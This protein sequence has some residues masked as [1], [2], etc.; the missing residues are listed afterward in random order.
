MKN[1]HVLIGE[2]K[3]LEN[4]ILKMETEYSDSDFMVEW[5]HVK[6][7]KTETHFVIMLAQKYRFNGTISPDPNNPEYL[8]LYPEGGSRQ[9]ARTLDIVYLKSFDSSF[10]D[11]I[12]AN[13]DA[14]I[15]LTKASDT[16]QLSIS[17]SINYLYTRVNADVYINN[18]NN[19]VQDTIRTIRNNYGGNLKLYFSKSWFVLSASDFLRSDEQDLD[20]R[21]TIQFGAGRNLIR[22][23][24]MF[25]ISSA[26]VALN[27]EKFNQ[28]NLSASNSLEVFYEVE[29]NLFGLEDIRLSTKVQFFTNTKDRER[30]RANIIFDAKFDLPLDFYIGGNITYNYDSKTDD[31]GS[32]SDYVIKS[33]VG[34]TF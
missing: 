21:T 27:S 11:R 15:S 9:F 7:L 1:G 33:S 20:L 25:L 34:W 22:N 29:Y 17:G 24:K 4:G 2:I 13:V 23:Y 3:V 26:G 28:E 8:I 10:W 31:V 12:S 16:K 5:E 19:V 18:L 6:S 32:Q 14:G 30:K